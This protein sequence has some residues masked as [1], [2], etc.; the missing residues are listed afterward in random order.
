MSTIV[1]LPNGS[2]HLFL[3]G[4]DESVFP[5]I[6]G[7]N[8]KTKRDKFRKGEEK[9]EEEEEEG[10][11]IGK[12]K[13]DGFAE[14]GLRTLVFGVRGLGEGEVGE[15]VA[16]F[17]FFFFFFFFFFLFFFCFVSVLF[18][19]CLLLLPFLFFFL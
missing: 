7:E 5:L 10:V 1:R 4:A 9:E 2:A 8:N 15:W 18:L 17:V 13:V 11:R 19:F 12:E 16:E 14:R 6:K 3:K